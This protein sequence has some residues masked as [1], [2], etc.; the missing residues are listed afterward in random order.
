[1]T[2]NLIYFGKKVKEKFSPLLKSL[3]DAIEGK[4]EFK[5]EIVHLDSTFK[6]GYI[7]GGNFDSLVHVTIVEIAT[8]H[9]KREFNGR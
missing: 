1:V 6:F 5:R 9:I 4:H 8:I 7:D 2:K 3:D